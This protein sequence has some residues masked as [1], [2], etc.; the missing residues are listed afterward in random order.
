[1]EMEHVNGSEREKKFDKDYLIINKKIINNVI[2]TFESKF[3]E[4]VDVPDKLYHL[5][6]Q[7]YAKKI[8]KYGISPKAKSKLTNHDYDGR[9]YVC[10]TIEDCK[11]LIRKMKQYYSEKI[12]NANNDKNKINIKWIV[13]EIDTKSAK[14]DKM[15]T[16]PN[17]FDGFYLLN[18]I[19][20]KCIR[21]IE[22]EN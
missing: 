3:D 14:I 15:Y 2:I 20:P 6:I 13:Y 12:F 10:K 7:E 1:M 4:I 11:F 8:E 16:D 21:M 19:D 17:Y 9:I 22:Q 18:H 5:S